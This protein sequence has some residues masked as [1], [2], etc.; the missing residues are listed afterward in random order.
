MARQLFSAC[1]EAQEVGVPIGN[2]ELARI[3]VDLNNDYQIALVQP[4]INFLKNKQNSLALFKKD[5]YDL[6]LV[7]LQCS[8][9][10][11][12]QEV[13]SYNLNELRQYYSPEWIQFLQG[14]LDENVITRLERNGPALMVFA[15]D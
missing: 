11:E 15:L 10:T 5:T 12:L 6:G 14:C 13:S 7:L 4:L 9:M 2:I 8:L 3:L 1:S